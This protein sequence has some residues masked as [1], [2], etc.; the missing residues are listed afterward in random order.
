LNPDKDVE[1]CHKTKK[2]WMFWIIALMLLG[3]IVLLSMVLLR[4]DQ[5]PVIP[6]VPPAHQPVIIGGDGGI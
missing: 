1:E 3:V 2:S 5:H 4:K 6:V